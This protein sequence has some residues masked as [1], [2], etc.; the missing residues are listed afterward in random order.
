[1]K[2]TILGTA[3]LRL[4][5][6]SKHIKA[7]TELYTLYVD[8]YVICLPRVMYSAHLLPRYQVDS[9]IN[10]DYDGIMLQLEPDH[11]SS[12][13]SFCDSFVVHSLGC[14]MWNEIELL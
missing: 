12:N 8:M 6:R 5:V 3:W 2:I 10:C 11:I 13:S 1:M 9:F 7:C 4:L 14:L